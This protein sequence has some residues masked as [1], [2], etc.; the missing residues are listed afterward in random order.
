[1]TLCHELMAGEL[2]GVNICGMLVCI[3]ATPLPHSLKNLSAVG[4][5]IHVYETEMNSKCI[6]LCLE[7]GLVQ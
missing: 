5:L 3:H 2:L 6:H 7:Q 4:G 1:M